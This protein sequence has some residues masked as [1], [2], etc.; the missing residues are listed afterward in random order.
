MNFQPQITQLAEILANVKALGQDGREIIFIGAS[1]TNIHYAT[2]E[3]DFEVPEFTP[4]GKTYEQLFKEL[5]QFAKDL[6]PL[7]V[8]LVGWTKKHLS[9]AV[10]QSEQYAEY[11]STFS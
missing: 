1:L 7:E 11:L 8:E 9:A 4:R 5:Q 3:P 10:I 6:K 2:G